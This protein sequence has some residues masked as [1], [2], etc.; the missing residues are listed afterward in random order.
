MAFN[1]KRTNKT[2][3]P[4]SQR[5]NRRRV[6]TWSGAAAAGLAVTA[7]GG[8]TKSVTKS[9]TNGNAPKSATASAGTPRRGGSVSI[10]QPAN[11]PDFSVFTASNNS[12][13]AA[14]PCYS[15][16]VKFKTGTGVAPDHLTLEPDMAQ[17]LPEQPDNLTYIFKLRPGIKFQNVPPINGRDLTVDD[18][19]QAIDAYRTNPQSAFREDFAAIDHVETPDALTVKLV[20]KQVWAPLLNAAAGQYGLRVFPPELLQGDLIKSKPI[21]TGPWILKQ[22]TSGSK[23]VYQ[24]NPDYFISE[25]PYLDTQTL[26][27]ITTTAGSETALEAGSVDVLGGIS[28]I[29]EKTIASK[30]SQDQ[31]A[32]L[33]SAGVYIALDTS[34]P[35]F[36]DVRV[37]RAVSM[38][39][40]RQAMLSSLYCGTGQN[41]QLIPV[42]F[43]QRVLHV[44]QLGTAA[45]YWKYDPQ[46]A[47][48]LLAEAGF[49]NGF[50][51]DF[52]YTPAYAVLSG[53][54]D[55]LQLA[56]ANLKQIGITATAV[57]HEY[58][59]WISSFY[60]P[61]FDWSGMLM[62]PTRYYPDIDYYARYWLDPKGIT[63]QS[64]VN[65]PMITSLLAK[66]QATLDDTERWSAMGDIEK[67]VA[68]QQYYIGLVQSHAT[69]F[70]PS[71]LQNYSLY[72]GYDQPQYDS[73]WSTK[74]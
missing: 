64:R 17:S 43:D 50:N 22:Y 16:L 59:Q 56:A 9:N 21:G 72:G 3:S 24:R 63:N 67:R 32:D 44:D 4:L 12:A 41:D 42:S 58:S 66:E 31:H 38:A 6:L 60:R 57:S 53:Y 19:K 30:V 48:Q 69:T 61:P 27:I 47:K 36:S 29:D 20:M 33:F 37:R 39:I 55:S 7:C 71:W 54:S 70:W 34:K 25:V 51:V 14:N 65:D 13:R 8:G 5:V 28:C 18:V 49:A 40:N 10:A 11:P 1:T 23:V 68:D 73:A 74:A 45:Q 35:P 2:G 52:H 15:K 62:G 26:Y 46:A